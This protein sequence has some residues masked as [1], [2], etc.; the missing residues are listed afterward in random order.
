MTLLSPS[1]RK[2]LAALRHPTNHHTTHE[3]HTRSP[4][5]GVDAAQHGP[6]PGVPPHPRQPLRGGRQPRGA[7]VGCVVRV[8]PC[9]WACRV[10]FSTRHAMDRTPSTHVMSPLLRSLYLSLPS[11]SRAGAAEGGSQGPTGAAA[12]AAAGSGVQL[13]DGM[14]WGGRRRGRVQHIGTGIVT[15]LYIENKEMGE[16]RMS[17]GCRAR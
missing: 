6:G 12:A 5:R 9:P 2:K 7:G 1:A 4:A 15:V 10:G 3:T 16:Q 14:G 11:Y 13:R 17:C 8:L